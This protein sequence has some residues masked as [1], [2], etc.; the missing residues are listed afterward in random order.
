MAF[1]EVIFKDISRKNGVMSFSLN[2]KII[3]GF[4]ILKLKRKDNEYK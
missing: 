4:K 3:L 2:K 1:N